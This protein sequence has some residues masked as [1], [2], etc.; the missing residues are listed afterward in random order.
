MTTWHVGYS[1]LEEKV[2]DW[3]SEF[4]WLEKLQTW[5]N[6]SQL[7]KKAAWLENVNGGVKRKWRYGVVY[8]EGSALTRVPLLVSIG[9]CLSRSI[10]NL[11]CNRKSV[12]MIGLVTSVPR[13]CQVRGCGSPNSRIYC[14]KLLV[15]DR[16]I[17]SLQCDIT[18]LETMQQSSQK[19]ANGSSSGN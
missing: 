3:L 19:H 18:F 11:C 12:P 5:R 15:F 9:R 17:L 1:W 16:I 7:G 2:L 4:N 14:Q 8:A 6:N 10:N 13:N